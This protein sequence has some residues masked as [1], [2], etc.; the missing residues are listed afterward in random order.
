MSCL[1]DNRLL[2]FNTPGVFK[3]IGHILVLFAFLSAI[4]AHWFVLQSVAWTTMLA[5]N[6]RTS[7][8][9]Q[10][11]ERTFD[12][13]H[14]CALC[15]K[16]SNSKQHEKK[17]EFRVEPNKFEFSYAPVTFLFLAPQDFREI[18]AP[19]TSAQLRSQTPL[20]PPPRSLLG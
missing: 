18:R 2:G 7:S 9:P 19:D 1:I 6:L 16:I 14:P 12:G 5:E 3:R 10:A 17:T 8:L 11:V 4:G 13:K 15:K 20:L